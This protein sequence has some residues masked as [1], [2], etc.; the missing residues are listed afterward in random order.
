MID[1]GIRYQGYC[2]DE[3][4]TVVTGT[5]TP[6][7]KEI[8]SIVKT[9]HDRA[10]DKVKPGVSSQEI[11]KAARSYIA[12]KDLEKYFVHATGHGVGLNLHEE[13]RISSLKKTNSGR[14]YG[15]YH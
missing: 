13:P 5:P 14:R 4:C 7:Q 10:I 8:F 3:T 9:A 11:D 6:K 1:F 12:K 15:F 2:S